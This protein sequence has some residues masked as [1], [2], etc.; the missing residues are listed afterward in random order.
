MESGDEEEGGEGG[1]SEEGEESDRENEK[2]MNW[3]RSR[4]KNKKM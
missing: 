3:T 4:E 1:G 2:I